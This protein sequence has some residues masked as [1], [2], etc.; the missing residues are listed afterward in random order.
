M[1]LVQ[2]HGGGVLEVGS[3]L[4]IE[5]EVLG[6]RPSPRTPLAAKKRTRWFEERWWGHGICK[7]EMSWDLEA[8]GPGPCSGRS[9][10]TGARDSE[11]SG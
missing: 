7:K 1:A 9:G 5:A 4:I 6:R 3:E 8:W 11:R 10:A 2:M